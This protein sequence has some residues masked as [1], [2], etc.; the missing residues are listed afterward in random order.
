MRSFPRFRFL[1]ALTFLIFSHSASSKDVCDVT[2]FKDH[3]SFTDHYQSYL[4]LVFTTD[5]SNF[6][7]R[8]KDLSGGASAIV[9]VVPVDAFVSYQSFDTW[10]S[11]LH[12]R[13]DY[14]R[15]ISQ[16]TA[17]LSTK[18][19]DI[20]ANAYRECLRRFNPISITAVS[21]QRDNV[22]FLIEWTAPPLVQVS[23]FR[24]MHTD[25]ANQT[26]PSDTGDFR[27]S[28]LG[29]KFLSYKLA[30][31]APFHLSVE[32]GPA[33]YSAAIDYMIVRYKQCRT[34]GNGIE[35]VTS[36]T[37]ETYVGNTR[38]GDLARDRSWAIAEQKLKAAGH[39]DVKLINA[40]YD[41]TRENQHRES[42]SKIHP[43][44][45]LF[46]RYYNFD[47]T[48]DPIYLMG[49]HVNC[50]MEVAASGVALR[51]TPTHLD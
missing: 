39:H 50:G 51:S 6:S 33:G 28:A 38:N 11:E 13:L 48:Y 20:D 41:N 14:K 47:V 17:Y 31:N 24:V 29:Q 15:T 8:Q 27:Y 37:V 7:Q 49:E 10:R 46:D 21:E 18:L 16:D 19:T 44:H 32:S 5:A 35:T 40:R 3:S 42:G 30:P 36:D 2:D 26:D 4:S 34:P 12:Q 45:W 22:T 23:D 25:A 9:G 1:A 43:G